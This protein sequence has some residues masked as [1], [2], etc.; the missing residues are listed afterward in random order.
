MDATART[1][2]SPQLA[3]IPVIMIAGNSEREAA[4]KSVQLGT[5]DFLVTPVHRNMLV[6]KV[7]RALTVEVPG[8]NKKWRERMRRRRSASASVTARRLPPRGELFRDKVS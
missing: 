5:V 4:A 1:K 6:I 7:D 8:E 3:I 2:S